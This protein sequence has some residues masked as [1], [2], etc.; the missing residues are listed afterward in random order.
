MKVPPVGELQIITKNFISYELGMQYSS[1]LR[2][3]WTEE[4]LT[5]T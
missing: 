5:S 4:L 2:G 3:I 1:E